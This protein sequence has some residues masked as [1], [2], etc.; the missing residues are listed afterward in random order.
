[1][2]NAHLPYVQVRFRIDRDCRPLPEEIFKK[3]IK[4]NYVDGGNK[5]KF[6]LSAEQVSIIP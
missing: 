3:A 6:E 5:F 1:M 4:D 2:T